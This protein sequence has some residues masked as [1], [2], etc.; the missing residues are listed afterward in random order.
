MSTREEK[1][2]VRGKLQIQDGCAATIQALDV[3]WCEEMSL[4]GG[5]TQ[6]LDEDTMAWPK[7][8]APSLMLKSARFCKRC[9]FLIRSLK[10]L[11]TEQFL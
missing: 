10:P 1:A 5:L 3:R 7:I 8:A 11:L 6:R 2:V 4:L 9:V